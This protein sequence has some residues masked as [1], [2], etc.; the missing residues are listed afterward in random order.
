MLV[1]VRDRLDQDYNKHFADL[2]ALCRALGAGDSAED[3]A[4]EAL[5]HGREHREQLRDDAKLEAWLRRI[6]ARRTFEHIRHQKRHQSHELVR[7][8]IPVDP[9][10]SIDVSAA[11][12]RLPERERVAVVLV[13]GVGYEQQEAGEVMNV[14]RGTVATLLHRARKHLAE[15][16]VGYAPESDLP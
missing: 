13:Y 1:G 7:A 11:I 12:T 6:A 3:I 2:T 8:F 10:I 16:L 9:S 15:L 5:L 14:T 4:Q